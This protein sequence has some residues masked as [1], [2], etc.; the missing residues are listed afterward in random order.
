M[1]LDEK[2]LLKEPEMRLGSHCSSR[3]QE[4]LGV[5]HESG[6]Y[7][8]LHCSVEFDTLH[9]MAVADTKM[10]APGMRTG[11]AR[12][13][14]LTTAQVKPLPCGEEMGYF[15]TVV[16]LEHT[17]SMSRA[18]TAA[19]AKSS[20]GNHSIQHVAVV[21]RIRGNSLQPPEDEIVGS[22]SSGYWYKEHLLA[23]S[24]CSA[25]ALLLGQD[26]RI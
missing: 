10:R 16:A 20:A 25:A 6:S 12:T 8:E 11:F 19:P 21:G 14:A 17:G 13:W 26:P 22:S 18:G 9:Y 1:P 5:R 23:G 15:R 2:L 7:V 4:P 3:T 24:R